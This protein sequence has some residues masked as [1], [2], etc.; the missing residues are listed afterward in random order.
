MFWGVINTVRRLG[1][2]WLESWRLVRIIYE[3]VLDRAMDLLIGSLL[4]GW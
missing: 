2:I 1:R 3:D 4:L